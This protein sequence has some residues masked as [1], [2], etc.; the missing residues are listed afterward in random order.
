MATAE[1]VK[2]QIQSLINAA[3]AATGN[4]DTDLT[5][6]V[7]ALIAGYST[8]SYALSGTWTFK[9]TLTTSNVS[10]EAI[11]FTANNQSYGKIQFVTVDGVD[12]VQ[13][14]HTTNGAMTVYYHDTKTWASDQYKTITFT[15]EQEV[16]EEFYNWF[17][18]NATKTA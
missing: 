7:Y 9:D 14:Y 2:S 11:T 5:T 17:I 1:S 4:N 12:Y 16:S 8:P 6:A 10:E 15:T 13:F 18:T 3:N